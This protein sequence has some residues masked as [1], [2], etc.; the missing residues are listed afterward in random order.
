ML[1]PMLEHLA[2][3]CFCNEAS[4]FRHRSSYILLALT[5]CPHVFVSRILDTQIN[6]ELSLVDAHRAQLT[7][8]HA[9]R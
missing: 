8:E 7:G 6:N 1:P 5:I 4:N 9:S 3:E 2:R